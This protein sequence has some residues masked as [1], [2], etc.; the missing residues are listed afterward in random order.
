MGKFQWDIK[1]LLEKEKELEQKVSLYEEVLATYR[2]MILNYDSSLVSFQERD[3]DYSSQSII[4]NFKENILPNVDPIQMSSLSNALNITKKYDTKLSP[5]NFSE[6]YL[7]NKELVEVS[8]HLFEKIPHKYFVQKAKFFADPKN[9]L[10]HIEHQSKTVTPCPGLTFVD[11]D[12][13]ISY[14]LISRRNTSLDIITLFHELFHMNIRKNTPPLFEN[15]NQSLYD[16]T[17]GYLANLIIYDL[18]KNENLYEEDALSFIKFNLNR[19][20]TTFTDAFIIE[21]IFSKF[22]KENQVDFKSLNKYLK[23]HD[24]NTPINN[25]NLLG[26]LQEDFK[27]DVDDAFSYLTAL[28]LYDLYKKAPEKAI[29]NLF[30]LPTLQGN[31]IQKDLE[32]I[33]V[34]FYQDG[35]QNLNKQCKR[36]LKRKTTS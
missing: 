7:N 27:N 17:E 28:D 15:E 31:N 13:H 19:N 30:L 5:N 10:L 1:L 12:K 8:I 3:D 35:Y 34:T 18:M 9:Q 36:L 6:C 33:G 21:S 20:V 4:K 14:G 23:A 29:N 25:K 2:Q 32:N 22:E 11:T 16:E 24:I 26:F